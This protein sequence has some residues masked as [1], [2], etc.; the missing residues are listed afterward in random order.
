[1]SESGETIILTVENKIK[2]NVFVQW[3]SGGTKQ[4]SEPKRI[5]HITEDGEYA[6]F[7]G[8][9]TGIPVSQLEI[10]EE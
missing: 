1:M 8:S 5:I 9:M 10:V 3:I 2:K 4:W 6:F 7:D